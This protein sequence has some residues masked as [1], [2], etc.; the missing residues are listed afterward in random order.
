MNRE[1]LEKEEYCMNR[2]T[3]EEL[4]NK[5]QTFLDRKYQKFPEIDEELTR[6]VRRIN[7]TQLSKSYKISTIQQINAN[8]WA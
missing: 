2:Y 3:D 7:V 1:L 5:I 4:T 6:P 8:A